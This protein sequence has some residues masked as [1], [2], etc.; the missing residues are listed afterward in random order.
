MSTRW[1]LPELPHIP[2][3]TVRPVTSPAFDAASAAPIYTV[4]RMW[5]ENET[6][7]YGL[8]LYAAGFF[9]EAHEVWEPVWMRSPG[10]SR[11]RLVVQ[12]LIQ[13]SNACLKILMGRPDAAAKL[14]DIAHQKVLEASYGGTTMMG[15][16]LPDL[17]SSIHAFN[18]RL[19]T[20]AG[21]PAERLP[22]RRPDLATVSQET[23]T[24][25]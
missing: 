1:P 12:G 20:S 8:D 7:L 25:V 24:P 5:P 9:W 10:N 19:A 21:Q 15:I 17:I 22:K 3:K 18:A 14:L 2:G 16:R 23:A 6:F 13:L 4:D 11:E